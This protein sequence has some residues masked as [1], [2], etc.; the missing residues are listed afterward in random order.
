MKIFNHSYIFIGICMLMLQL[1]CSEKKSED[2]KQDYKTDLETRNRLVEQYQASIKPGP[3]H[4]K[5]KELSGHWRYETSIFQNNNTPPT[6]VKGEAFNET[7][8][9]DRFLKS[10]SKDSLSE[11]YT[12]IGFDRRSH[13]FTMVR[14]DNWGTY[15]VTSTS[16][17][18]QADKKW[19][20]D[21]MTSGESEDPI[22]MTNQIYDMNIKVIS[23]DEYLFEIIFHDE[24][25]ESTFKGVETKYTRLENEV[26]GD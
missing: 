16:R 13:K 12:I 5:I 23:K 1:S 22:F 6:I 14:F 15:Y 8:L 11:D 4:E 9:G 10:H 18:S 7:I 3:E 19:E 20:N 2:E 24:V 17:D 21:I 26:Q 25:T